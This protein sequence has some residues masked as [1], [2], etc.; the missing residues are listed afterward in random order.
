MFSLFFFID[1]H[2]PVY[3]CTFS[4]NFFYFKGIWGQLE[5]GEFT[6]E[7][8]TKKFEEMAHAKFGRFLPEEIVKRMIDNKSVVHPYPQMIDAIE[9]LRAEGIK[10][11][12]LTN[13]FLVSKDQSFLPLDKQLFN[14]V[15]T[16]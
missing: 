5:R 11:A 6:A 7:E 9:C 3:H 4:S 2:K 1:K 13:N 12:L 16:T 8:Y 15:S 14:V 10:T